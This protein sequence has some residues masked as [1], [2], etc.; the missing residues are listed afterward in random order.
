MKPDRT[1]RLA[2]LVLLALGSMAVFIY[3]DQIDVIALENWLA[4]HPVSAPLLFV[5]FFI[6]M[7][8]L[9][10]PGTLLSLMGGALFGPLWGSVYNQISAVL[11]ATL[12]FLAARYVAADWVE[13]KLAD[14]VKEFKA[15]VEEKG[16]RFVLLVRLVPV[17][18]FTIL[19]YALGLTRIRLLH[20][21]TV[22]FVCIFPRVIVYSYAGYTGRKAIAGEE[23]QPQMLMIM[24][25]LI[26]MSASVIYYCEHDAQPKAFPDIPTT[27]WWSVITLTT[28]GYGDVYP[29]TALGRFA[30][31]L[32][33]MFGIGMVALPTGILG[34]GFVEEVSQR[35]AGPRECPHCGEALE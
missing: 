9:F 13:K 14:N 29:I 27:M 12:T 4:V 15:G 22:S 11:G 3:R 16:W 28:V 24:G 35:K 30:A 31:A 17:I 5:L 18:P 32:I 10:F 6:V 2:L 26:V 25:L 33:A 19:N 7:T 8:L 20:F 34:A 1:A 23:I 21:V